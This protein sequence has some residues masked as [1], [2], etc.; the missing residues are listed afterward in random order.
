M[1]YIVMAYIV[2]A[3]VPQRV[4]F[5]SQEE[6]DGMFDYSMTPDG[7]QVPVDCRQVSTCV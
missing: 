1:A 6:L 5:D 2:M 3:Q 7:A 4:N